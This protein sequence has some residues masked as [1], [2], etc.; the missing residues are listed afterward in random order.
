MKNISISKTLFS[1]LISLILFSFQS[2]L[3][4]QDTSGSDFEN[5][6]LKVGVVKNSSLIKVEIKGKAEVINLKDLYSLLGINKLDRTFRSIASLENMK[7][8]GLSAEIDGEALLAVISGY[9]GIILLI[10]DANDPSVYTY[11]AI[12]Q[13]IVRKGEKEDLYHSQEEGIQRPDLVSITSS[14]VAWV[15]YG[16][17]GMYVLNFVPLVTPKH[18]STTFEGSSS[19]EKWDIKVLGSNISVVDGDKTL[20]KAVVYS[21]F[22]DNAESKKSLVKWNGKS[23]SAE[24]FTFNIVEDTRSMAGN[25]ILLEFTAEELAKLCNFKEKA[26]WESIEIVKP[27]SNLTRE[28]LSFMPHIVIARNG[29]GVLEIPTQGDEV[30]FYNMGNKP[31]DPNEKD[32][33]RIF[34][35]AYSING[36]GTMFGYVEVSDADANSQYLALFS[37][38]YRFGIKVELRSSVKNDYSVLSTA[39][40]VKLKESDG[41]VRASVGITTLQM[42]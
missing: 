29:I 9:A 24:E 39:N 21:G 22:S 6:G 32:N 41:N 14:G 4:G 7:V 2:K 31:F 17:G 10:V 28:G 34:R 27:L 23:R 42:Y 35:P 19:T 33:P 30:R 18:I 20:L 36:I 1:F 12:K 15:S 11:T 40:F 37:P 13:K 3:Q 16:E 8:K 25:D 38:Q 26:S 5:E